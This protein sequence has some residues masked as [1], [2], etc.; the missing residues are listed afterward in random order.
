[1]E[2]DFEDDEGWDGEETGPD[3]YSCS[4]CQHTQAEPGMG[5]GCDRCGLFNVMEEEYY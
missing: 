4:C 5:N 1:M 3:Y 2:K